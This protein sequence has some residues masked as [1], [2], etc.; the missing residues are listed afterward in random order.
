MALLGSTG[1]L[2]AGWEA[3]NED[4]LASAAVWATLGVFGPIAEGK[5]VK[6]Q[7]T[8][9]EV[10][11]KQLFGQ[12][13]K[14]K[15][16]KDAIGE[17][18]LEIQTAEKNFRD[19]PA[20]TEKGMIQQKNYIKKL[21]KRLLDLESTSDKFGSEKSLVAEKMFQNAGLIRQHKEMINKAEEVSKIQQTNEQKLLKGEE[22]APIT[23]KMQNE[24]M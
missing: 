10:Q 11:T 21:E 15:L 18:R 22:P 2:S 12:L 19:N 1:Y 23:E 6:R 8:D 7:L 4:R 3:S 14:P 16:V 20:P 13:E 5:P 9:L 17:V 24:M